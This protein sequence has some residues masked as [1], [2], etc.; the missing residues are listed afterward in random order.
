[1]INSRLEGLTANL[2]S[3]NGLSDDWI[4]DLSKR[5]LIA[6]LIAEETDKSIRQEMFNKL[7]PEE[8]RKNLVES[9]SEDSKGRKVRYYRMMPVDKFLDLLKSGVW[10]EET[11]ED[12]DKPNLKELTYYIYD[13]ARWTKSFDKFDLLKRDNVAD[14]LADIFP[15]APASELG[16]LLSANSH[17]EVRKF[18]AKYADKTALRAMHRGASTKFN[19]YFSCSV[20]GPSYSYRDGI[21]CLEMVIPDEE[22]EYDELALEQEKEVYLRKLNLSWVTRVYDS[23]EKG[24]L[25]WIDEVVYNPDLP[26]G[27]YT[28]NKYIPSMDASEISAWTNGEKTRGCVP[29]DLLN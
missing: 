23:G 2:E 18:F 7:F 27:E 15:T 11:F 3:E 22:V 6:E 19:P 28:Q 24:N 26:L 8:R 4:K 17:S 14:F 10:D 21:V 25:Q 16:N 5:E 9:A 13:L 1:M 12:D 20:G 29:V